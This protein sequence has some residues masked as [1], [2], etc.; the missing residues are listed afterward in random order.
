MPATL[1]QRGAR[2]TEVR[3][4]CFGGTCA[5]HAGGSGELG[6]AVAH[7]RRR[8]EA[9]HWRLTRFEPGSE[10]SRLNAAS[11]PT[12]RVS[13]L[14]CLFAAGA[15]TAARRTDGLVDP[16]VIDAVEKA[17][18]VKTLDAPLPLPQTLALAPM[19]APARP[20]SDQSWRRVG[21]DVRAR[22]VTRPAGVRLDSG[23]IAKGLCADLGARALREAD[24]Y[25]VDCC[26]D[27]R[28]G[29][30]AGLARPVLVDDPFGRGVVHEFEVASGA[31][32]TSGIGRRS[33]LD[34]SGRPAHHIID[35]ATGRP[36]FTGIVQATALAPTAV[37]AETRA[38]AALLSG[39]DGAGRWLADGGVVV[40]DDGS[41]KV[42]EAA[43]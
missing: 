7:V 14:L 33:W 36:A 30:R 15:V 17:G 2:E 35:P 32:A 19:R 21:V 39:P 9:W 29:G 5:V 31:V 24:T 37:E 27:L 11:T 1:D 26:G 23:G 16:T 41:H 43:T 13:D 34:G 38:K 42:F 20:R 10:L 8:F 28:I 40:F 12:V 18:Y 6:V 4:D 3:F 25:A 22:T